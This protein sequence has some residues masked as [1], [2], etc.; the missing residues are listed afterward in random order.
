GG[1][2]GLG[3]EGARAQAAAGKG[4][5]R[6]RPAE[7]AADDEG[8]GFGH[9]CLRTVPAL[10]LPLLQ[11]ERVGVRGLSANL[12]HVEAPLTPPLSPQ[13]RGEGAQAPSKGHA[14]AHEISSWP[15]L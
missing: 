4:R 11:G 7:R 12:L 9:G 8:A 15:G 3:W 2:R 5:P 6:D 14:S 1:T 10:P 13:G